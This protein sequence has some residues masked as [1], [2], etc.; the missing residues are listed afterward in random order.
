MSQ[1]R[2]DTIKRYQLVQAG[3]DGTLVPTDEVEAASKYMHAACTRE[4]PP[5]RNAFEPPLGVIV[6]IDYKPGLS[7]NRDKITDHYVVLCDWDEDSK[8][9]RGLNPG[10]QLPPDMSYNVAFRYDE[11]AR[12]WYRTW[13]GRLESTHISMV[14]PSW[15]HC[16]TLPERP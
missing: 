3:P 7:Q 6:G 13:P 15:F 1:V 2:E 11:K 4:Q 9:L 16:G 5:M 8:E 14:I 12:V 10:A